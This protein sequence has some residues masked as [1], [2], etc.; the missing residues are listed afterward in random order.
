MNQL[1]R[2]KKRIR[3]LSGR[4]LQ[5]VLKEERRAELQYGLINGDTTIHS[6]SYWIC[7]K[8]P[9][10]SL[11]ELQAWAS[12][13]FPDLTPKEH[14]DFAE[15]ELFFYFGS[16]CFSETIAKADQ[17]QALVFKDQGICKSWP[18]V[19]KDRRG[20]TLVKKYRYDLEGVI[21][22]YLYPD[23]EMAYQDKSGA[24]TET[25]SEYARLRPK[26][27]IERKR[28]ERS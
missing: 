17:T 10:Y 7:P 27:E 1:L 16:M 12:K 11:K 22:I 26:K 8:H 13:L 23:P 20:N 28:A 19:G 3:S 14:K 5:V 21:R 4:K 18:K 2:I 15:T 9:I 6:I 24:F 25:D